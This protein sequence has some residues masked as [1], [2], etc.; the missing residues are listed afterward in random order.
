MNHSHA[1]LAFLSNSS[2]PLTSFPSIATLLQIHEAILNTFL[3]SFPTLSACPSTCMRDTLGGI[4]GIHSCR[5]KGSDVFLG[6]QDGTTM[7][8]RAPSTTRNVI[9]KCLAIERQHLW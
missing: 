7:L 9:G 3:V 8:Q 2:T 5:S 4:T 6:S 1:C